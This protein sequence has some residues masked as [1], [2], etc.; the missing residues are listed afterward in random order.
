MET[1]EQGNKGTKSSVKTQLI[2]TDDASIALSSIIEKRKNSFN[3]QRRLMLLET[4][5][6]T[7]YLVGEQNIQIVGNTIKPLEKERSTMCVA[8][9]ILPAVQK[10]VAVSTR[11]PP[12]FDVIPAGT[13]DDDKATAIVAQKVLQYLQRKF[14]KGLK[15]GQTVL[16]YDIAGVGWR[17][18][19]WD[20]DETVLGIN[21][22]PVDENNQ[23]IQGHVSSIPVGEA[24]TQGNVIVDSI[25]PNQLIYDFRITDLS[26]LKW[27][28]HAKHISY[29]EVVMAI[30]LE[31]AELIKSKF[32]SSSS[33]GET[34][35]ESSV[36]RRFVSMFPESQKV[37]TASLSTGAEMELED[38][39][40]ADYYEYWHKPTKS[41]PTGCFAV[42]V[43]DQLIT[44]SPFPIQSYPHGELPFIPACPMALDDASIGAISR[45]SQARPLQREYNGLRSQIKEN[46]DIMGNSVFMAPR[47]AKIVYKTLDNRAGNIIEYDGPVG[48][49]T[50]EP[51]VPMSGQIF[52]HL[53]QT[54]YAID[55]IFAFHEA[56]R[57]VAPRNIQSGKGLQALQNAD[58]AQLGPMIEGFEDSDERV[59]Y[60]AVMVGVANYEPGRLLN[61][62]GSDYEWTTYELDRNQMLGKFN[63]I[64]RPKSS[65][66]L[67]KEAS[68]IQAFEVWRS[69]L[70]GN[71]QDTDLRLWTLD[72]MH[73]GN[74]ESLLQKH[75]KQKNFA[76]KEFAAAYANIK[77]MPPITDDVSSEQLV[78]VIE[79]YV[80]V[81]AV[82][83]FD[84]HSLHI[85][86]HNEWL[87]DKFWELRKTGNPIMIEFLQRVMNHVTQHQLI[88][89]Q[90]AEMQ[91]Q[92][93][94]MREML[95]KGKTMDQIALSKMDLSPKD[96]EKP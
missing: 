89:Q 15:R 8:N 86:Y 6:N 87:L 39:K 2:M 14:G 48:K 56:S 11:I 53:I 5:V 9:C 54:K 92:K 65:M 37:N 19:Y 57:G 36:I 47:S 40:Y 59:A 3:P 67:D 34:E 82:N 91:Y 51:G 17:K 13:D 46:N 42:M 58:M 78:A 66:P 43:G 50:R 61:V 60:Q 80:F 45:I 62:V 49:P 31:N 63:I 7:S 79:Q 4:Q 1:N 69:G 29:G 77:D 22:P 23:S 96:K 74:T 24:I 38:D 26:K 71:P 75:S 90:V 72:Q 83:S 32:I 20:P 33:G 25:P 73:L 84:D 41:F 76:I 16:W 85:F 35:F 95:V 10:D 55:E 81:P 88:M 52:N 27:I 21:P 30:G 18:V 12:I 70:L 64:I 94:L 93:D 68:A 44:N 28:I